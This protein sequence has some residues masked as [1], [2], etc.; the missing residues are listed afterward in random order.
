MSM[1]IRRFMTFASFIIL[2]A[3][4]TMLVACKREG[5]AKTATAP[6]STKTTTSAGAKADLRNAKIKQVISTAA[7]EQTTDARLGDR[8]NPQGVVIEERNTFKPG[9]PVVLSMTV[10]QSPSG[11]QMSAVWRD[12]K[13][14]VLDQDRK[15]MNGE[16][17]ATFAY[18]GK[19]LKAGDYVV[20]GY[21][22]GNIA[23][24]K[25]FKVE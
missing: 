18:K 15:S 1:R 17:T 24:E 19:K 10:K 4:A 16:K 20:T 23:T 8:A 9:Q 22:G 21:W 13:G 6:S 11:L 12:G 3:A 7:V 2:Y 14:Q 25:K 5:A